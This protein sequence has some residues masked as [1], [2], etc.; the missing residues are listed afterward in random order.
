MVMKIG[1]NLKTVLFFVLSICFSCSSL[2]TG[3]CLLAA[4][5]VEKENVFLE[6][7]GVH[8]DGKNFL[9]ENPYSLLNTVRPFILPSA[10]YNAP[11]PKSV[12][13]ASLLKDLPLLKHAMEK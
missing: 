1:L 9:S 11:H 8:L 13:I 5:G 10:W 4:Q 7:L 2:A 3:L 12:N 6:S